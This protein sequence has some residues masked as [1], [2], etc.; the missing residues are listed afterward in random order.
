[1]LTLT[2]PCAQVLINQ[3]IETVK[4]FIENKEDG[5]EYIAIL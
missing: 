2:D 1:M 4:I 3:P 5:K